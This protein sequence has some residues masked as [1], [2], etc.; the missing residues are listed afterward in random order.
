[1][2]STTFLENFLF[3]SSCLFDPKNVDRLILHIYTCLQNNI[4]KHYIAF[5][6]TYYIYIH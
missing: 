1:M 2:E 6:P 5:V 4:R 3:P